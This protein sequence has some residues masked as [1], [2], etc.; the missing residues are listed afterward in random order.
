M[1]QKKSE[2]INLVNEIEKIWHS[3]RISLHLV[4]F[5]LVEEKSP[6]PSI[7]RSLNEIF[8]DEGN[9]DNTTGA[10]SV[11]KHPTAEGPQPSTSAAGNVL[12][13]D[14][15]SNSG[16]DSQVGS[17]QSEEPVKNDIGKR[18]KRKRGGKK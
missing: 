4:S 7:R 17:Q 15:D 2:E 10:S 13:A 6:V 8:N 9:T 18:V 3:V 1:P 14:L 5:F 16:T 12:T 11:T